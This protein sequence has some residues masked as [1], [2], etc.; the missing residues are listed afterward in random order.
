MSDLI[1]ALDGALSKIGENMILRRPFG[2]GSNVQF[3]SVTCRAR[4]SAVTETQIAAGITQTELNF[5][6]SPTQI[7][8]AQWPGGHV[9]QLPPF[10]I[11]QRVPRASVDQVIARGKVRKVTFV[12]PAFVNGELVRINGRIE[13]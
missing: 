11:D 1:D 8:N 10:D 13:G 5:V 12:D 2:M 4:I 9:E 7:N 3:V 6:I